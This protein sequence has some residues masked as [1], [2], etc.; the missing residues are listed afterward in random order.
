MIRVGTVYQK[1]IMD[2][3]IPNVTCPCCNSVFTANL[4]RSVQTAT[5]LFIP[6]MK[7]SLLYYSVCPNCGM[8]YIL[9]KTDY[10]QILQSSLASCSNEWNKICS[11]SFE[12][13]IKK[14]NN[15][16]IRSP[17]SALLASVLS[18]IFG[19]LGL[20][21]LYMGHKKR[22]LMNILFFILSI[23]MFALALVLNL[24]VLCVPCALLLATNV[25]WG[26]IDLVRILSGHAK[27]LKG[28]YLLTDS[29]YKK[30]WIAYTELRDK[31][32]EY[33]TVQY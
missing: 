33:S 2:M 21:N 9:N 16:V 13:Q 4:S 1:E 10:A 12:K 14:I 29:Q 28:A 5:I 3:T 30:R 6:C 15:R 19:L 18:L 24:L 31:I 17:K 32:N 20:Q 22:F 25:Y 8:K 27:D 26:I 7:K 23:V 11:G